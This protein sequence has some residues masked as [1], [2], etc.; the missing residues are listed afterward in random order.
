MEY[1]ATT[2]RN[3]VLIYATIWICLEN[4]MLSERNQT[5]KATCLYEMSRIGKSIETESRLAVA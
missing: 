3:E 4:I 2:K 1:Y 5:Q